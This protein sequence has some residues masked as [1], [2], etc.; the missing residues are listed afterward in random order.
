MGTGGGRRDAGRDDV[1][2]PELIRL[3]YTTAAHASGPRPAFEVG[4]AVTMFHPDKPPREGVVCGV[5]FAGD[6]VVTE[7]DGFPLFQMKFGRWLY[8]IQFPSLDKAM[9]FTGRWDC[10]AGVP[11]DRLQKLALRPASEVL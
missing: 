10:C 11:G 1:T 8:A 6:P 4:E 3:A 5:Q 9:R 7:R 2:A